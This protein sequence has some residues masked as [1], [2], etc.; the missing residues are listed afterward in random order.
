MAEDAFRT[1]LREYLPRRLAIGQGE[2]IDSKGQH[3]TQT[4]V[5]IVNEDHPFTFKDDLPA[6][7]FIEGVVGA[8][9]IKSILTSEQLKQSIQNSRVFK[10]LYQI[11]GVGTMINATRSDIE[12]YYKSP[13]WFLFAYE[14]QLDLA[15]I[16]EYLVKA[17]IGDSLESPSLLDAIFVL[18]KG[19]I[20]NFGD[21]KGIFQFR[22]TDGESKPGWVWQYDSSSLFWL[23]AWFSTVM[24]RM[25]RY[26]PILPEYLLP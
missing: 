8:A 1:F 15:T 13:P 6:M 10:K 21:G 22:A 5:V 20:I 16:H 14:S 12:R 2:I 25:V 18:G 19:W 9:E 17:S 26:K 11:P 7:F 23:M 24:P 3:S 4:D